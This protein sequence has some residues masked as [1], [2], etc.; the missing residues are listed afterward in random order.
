MKIYG[1]PWSIN[2]RKTLLVLAEKRAEADLV[3][4]MIPKG[5]QKRPEHLALHPFG[6][7][8]VLEDDGFVLFETSAINRYLD[9]KLGGAPLVPHDRRAAALVDQWTHVADVYFAPHAGPTIVETLFRR[10][11]GGEQNDAA[12]RSGREGMQPALDALDRRL[13]RNEYLA[14]AD[15]SLADIQFMPYLEYLAKT[16]E[17]EHV[18]RRSHLHRWWRT[19]EARDTWKKVARTG[20]QPYETGMTAETIERIHRGAA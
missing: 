15:F 18:E 13:A 12:L 17:A 7:V 6:K 2:T 20:P 4:V 10:Y 19:V 16:G 11:L 1:H 9:E 8:P 14:G 3:L 5:E